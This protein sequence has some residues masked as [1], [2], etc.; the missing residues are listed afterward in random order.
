MI[1]VVYAENLAT[2][3]LFIL[4]FNASLTVFPEHYF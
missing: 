2:L 3:K 1:K 4:A